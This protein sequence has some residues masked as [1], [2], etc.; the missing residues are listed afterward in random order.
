MKRPYVILLSVLAAVLLSAAPSRAQDETFLALRPDTVLC[1][2]VVFGD[3]GRGEYTLTVEDPGFPPGGWADMHRSSF[4]S[5]PEN[6]VTTPVCFSTRNRRV[7]E[8]ATVTFTVESPQGKKSTQYGICVS[9]HEDS[10]LVESDKGPCDATVSH[11]DV[12][13][14]DLAEREKYAA[15]GETV[16]FNVLVS[17]EFDAAV[18]LSKESGPAMTIGQATLE[19]PG[20]H[21]VELSVVAPQSAGDAT[22]VIRASAAG[23]ALESCSKTVSGV[24]HVGEATPAQPFSIELSPSDKNVAGTEPAKFFITVHNFQASQAFSITV[25]FDGSA[26]VSDFT[27]I[28]LRV[29]R[30]ESTMIDFTVVAQTA[31]HRVYTIVAGAADASGFRKTSQAVLTV[32]EPVSD[33]Q[34][35]AESDPGLKDAADGFKERYESGPSLDDWESVSTEP[36]SGTGQAAGP[37]PVNWLLIAGA[38]AGALLIIFYIYRR[39]RVYGE[40]QEMPER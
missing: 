35:R 23:C 39:T 1:I 20:D 3:S 36:P 27:P 15:P 28:Q 34:R 29:N 32:Q 33:A 12:F 11:T 19:M 5:G 7:G 6:P 8:Q 40:L 4:V 9:N 25:E 24:I 18:T 2:P 16:R 37:A 30:D 26:L 10:D 17:S 31:A 13:T 22:F 21:N 38:A 14:L